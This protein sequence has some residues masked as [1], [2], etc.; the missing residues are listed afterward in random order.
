M[1][2]FR[3]QHA[4]LAA[5]GQFPFPGYGPSL[6]A[7]REICEHPGVTV[8]EL[9]WLTG[10]PKSRVSVLMSRLAAQRIVGK[11]GD[12]RDSRLVRLRITPEGRQCVADWT[13][14]SQQAIGALLPPLG[15]G[16]RAARA[17]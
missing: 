4:Q 1:R 17:G 6:A 10:L 9:A 7:V 3:R 11:D 5:G 14:A 12:S 2:G 16:G 15:D 13:V 8:N